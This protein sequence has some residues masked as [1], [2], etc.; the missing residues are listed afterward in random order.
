MC[1][2]QSKNLYSSDNQNK[3][4]KIFNE[5]TQSLETIDSKIDLTSLRNPEKSL[6]FKLF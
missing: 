6:Y 4:V 2:C 3:P 1:Y 5:K